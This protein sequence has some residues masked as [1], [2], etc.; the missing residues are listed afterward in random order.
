MAIVITRHELAQIL[1]DCVNFV[2]CFKQTKI[3]IC[4]THNSTQNNCTERQNNYTSES[5]KYCNIK[6]LD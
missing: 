6:R 2:S 5:N 3:L 4:E 1:C